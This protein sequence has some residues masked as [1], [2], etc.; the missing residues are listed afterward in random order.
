M[1]PQGSRGACSGHLGAGCQDPAG[2]SLGTSQLYQGRSPGTS[3]AGGGS[4]SRGRSLWSLPAPGSTTPRSSHR[5]APGSRA[6]TP[7]SG[8][9]PPSTAW[10]PAHRCGNRHQLRVY[11]LHQ[12]RRGN[13]DGCHL[14][15]L[16]S[17]GRL[18]SRRR[19]QLAA[20]S[21]PGSPCP[22][23]VTAPAGGRWE[24]ALLEPPARGHAPPAAPPRLWATSSRA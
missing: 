14:I 7:G 23:G 2:N 4:G 17:L 12:G 9:V 10:H 3:K 16:G 15:P 13:L 11:F 5:P 19:A 22:A 1:E 18:C 6:G 20:A 21:S 24:G 8:V